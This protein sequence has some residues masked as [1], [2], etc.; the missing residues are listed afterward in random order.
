MFARRSH[1]PTLL[2]AVI[3]MFVGSPLMV[4]MPRTGSKT[5]VPVLGEKVAG[6]PA[7]ILTVLRCVSSSG[8]EAVSGSCEQLIVLEATSVIDFKSWMT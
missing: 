6:L 5:I 3:V 1:E 2:V 4:A 8:D 7:A